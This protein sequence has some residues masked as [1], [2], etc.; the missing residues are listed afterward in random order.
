MVDSYVTFIR[1]HCESCTVHTL[2]LS[3]VVGIENYSMLLILSIIFQCNPEINFPSPVHI[4]FKL[5]R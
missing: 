3:T 1:Y 2:I 4:M 5:R